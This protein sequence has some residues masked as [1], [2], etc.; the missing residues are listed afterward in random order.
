M[1]MFCS[2]LW[3]I[4]ASMEESIHLDSYLNMKRE[5]DFIQ[6]IDIK[7]SFV[8]LWGTVF[9]DEMCSQVSFWVSDPEKLRLIWEGLETL[10]ILNFHLTI[11]LV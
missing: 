7:I 4:P 9:V 8:G 5:I 10:K 11:N 6:E 1:E 2:Y 3:L